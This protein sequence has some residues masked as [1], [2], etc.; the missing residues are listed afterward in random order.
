M[1]LRVQN[2]DAGHVYQVVPGRPERNYVREP[3]RL[4][5]SAA[6]AA[7]APP[8][9]EPS[10]HE[11]GPHESDDHSYADE[12]IGENDSMVMPLSV[13]RVASSVHRLRTPRR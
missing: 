6:S 2:F 13:A 11:H 7:L 12:Q 5:F 1:I 8:S 4:L 10:D 9:D 3:G